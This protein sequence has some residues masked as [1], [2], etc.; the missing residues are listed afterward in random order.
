MKNMKLHIYYIHT[1]LHCYILIKSAKKIGGSSFAGVA[2][3]QMTVGHRA[4]HEEGKTEY[5]EEGINS[6][7]LDQKPP[8]NLGAMTVT[9]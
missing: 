2:R 9:I 1:F 7:L 5:P 3:N 6:L 8:Q 4:G